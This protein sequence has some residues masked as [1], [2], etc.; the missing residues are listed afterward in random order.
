M[1]CSV[2]TTSVGQKWRRPE[3][4]QG[5]PQAG[6]ATKLLTRRCIYAKN[7]A[8]KA[9]RA[10]EVWQF[11]RFVTKLS[12]QS[13]IAAIG[14][15]PMGHGPRDAARAITQVV[16]VS[17]WVI[18][19][20]GFAFLPSI[21]TALH[22]VDHRFTVEGYVCGLDGQPLSDIPVLIKDVR[23]SVGASAL[24]DESGYYKAVL[25]LHNENKGDPIVVTMGDEERRVTARFD[26]GDVQAERTIQVNFGSGCE[27]SG[28]GPPRW[29]YYGAGIG[30]VAVSV[31]AG[32][33]LFRR[34]KQSRKGRKRRR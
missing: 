24:T 27:L 6:T 3:A 2:C 17:L 15:T 20:G 1:E 34:R 11:V 28:D 26:E 14:R 13:G 9:W 21:T 30:I 25:H 16:K 31:F 5:L 12:G 19:L 22:K 4:T 23:V 7:F 29:V 32:A 8:L 10:L 33:R 18:W